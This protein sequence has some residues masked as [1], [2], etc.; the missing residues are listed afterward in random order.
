MRIAEIPSQPPANV[1]GSFS[2]AVP[3]AV[4]LNMGRSGGKNCSRSCPM[5]PDSVSRFAV[6]GSGRCY[7]ATIESGF[8]GR[9]VRAKLDR[10]EESDAGDV[11]DVADAQL[12]QRRYRLPWFRMSAFGSVPDAIPRGF[13]RMLKRL[14]DAGTPIHFPI[15]DSE[16]VDRY[17]EALPD[18]IAVRYSIPTGDSETW[19]TY[20][21]ACSTVA[22]SMDDRP[23]ERIADARG[24]ASE[25][26]RATGRRTIVCPAVVTSSMGKQ[27]R[28]KD[29]KRVKCGDCTHCADPETDVVYPVHA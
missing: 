9:N 20:G 18:G 22:G 27:K 8:K 17:R 26:R 29:I 28:F 11:I 1:L 15:E 6:P 16:R 23:M 3:G 4:A 12:R 5:H 7:A 19:T 25:R 13:V 24:C 14:Q 2:K 21:G 10:I